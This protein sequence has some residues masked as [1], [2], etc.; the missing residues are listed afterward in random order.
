[1][2]T[3]SADLPCEIHLSMELEDLFLHF[4]K[5]FEA[6]PDPRSV[7]EAR[8]TP[9]EV[10]ALSLWFSQQWGRPRMWCED[11]FQSDLSNEIFAS[12]QEMFGA[13]LLVRS[14]EHTSELQ[15]P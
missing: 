12:R 5:R 4:F 11:T 7:A 1:M 6:L 9:V 13:L 10:E 15:S 2:R 3:P 8:I 14:E